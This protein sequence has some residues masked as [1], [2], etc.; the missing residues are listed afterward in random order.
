MKLRVLLLEDDH[1]QR[2]DVQQALEKGLGA[3]VETKTTE[4]EFRR[5]FE[6][7]ASNPPD[8]AVLDVMVRWANPSRDMPAAPQEVTDN[9]EKAGIRCARELRD[10]ARTKAVKVILYSVLGN[11]DMGDEPLPD[12]VI[13]V[14]KETDFA[15]L[16]EKVKEIAT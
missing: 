12:D 10:D 8:V 3:A 9:P 2:K 15:N 16:L 6:E 11:E 14:V 13:G 1:L 7:I 5:D 4:S